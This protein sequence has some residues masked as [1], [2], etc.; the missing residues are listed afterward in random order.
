MSMSFEEQC[1]GLFEEL[2]VY[3][4]ICAYIRVYTHM[5]MYIYIYV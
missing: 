4:D 5:Y 1:L 3:T 2:F